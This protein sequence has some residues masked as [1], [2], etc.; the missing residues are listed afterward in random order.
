[1]IAVTPERVA[2]LPDHKIQQAGHIILKSFYRF[3]TEG[4]EYGADWPTMRIVHPDR[5]A[6]WDLL[7]AEWRRRHPQ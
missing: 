6:A 4:L 2:A 3:G 5:C 1:M 7:K